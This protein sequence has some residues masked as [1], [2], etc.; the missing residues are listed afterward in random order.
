L[1]T[2]KGA[3][4]ARG[5]CAHQVSE[6][7]LDKLLAG[8]GRAPARRAPAHGVGAGLRL[9]R[10]D[11]ST[12]MRRHGSAT[13][14]G[15]LRAVG[16]L[17]AAVASGLASAASPPPPVAAIR[18]TA[19]P[20]CPDAAAFVALVGGHTGGA[21]DVR[22]AGAAPD[23][24]VQIRDRAGGR[25]GSVRRAAAAEDG[26]REIAAADCRELVE[27]LALSTALSLGAPPAAPPPAAAVSAAPGRPPDAPAAPVA[28]TFGAGVLATFVLPGQPMPAGSLFV[29][30][31]HRGRRAGL[32]VHTPDV[33]L[34]LAHAR[35]D[36]F[37][38]ERARFALSTA[39]LALCP[40]D[41][42]LGRATTLRLC[43]A[44]DVGLLEGEG[45]AVTTPRTSRFFFA[46]GGA[47]LGLRWDAGRHVAIEAQAAVAAPLERTRFV[48][49]MPRIEVARVPA[50]VGEGGVT[51]GLAIP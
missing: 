25:V 23:L 11:G 40:A 7:D 3:A 41:V 33:R 32:A 48:F 36:L 5:F 44:A 51:V 24:L 28:W 8:G 47:R 50:L 39:G 34:A 43:A 35:N 20:G 18:Y 1:I 21:W 15:V 49:E 14:A 46:A 16:L 2:E 22:D 27:A 6:G 26:A 4:G 45:V 37:G 9:A 42:G 19:P 30:L 29:E 12:P 38:A 10:A 13:H 17:A 31:G